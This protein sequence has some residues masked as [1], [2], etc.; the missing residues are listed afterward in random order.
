MQQILACLQQLTVCNFWCVINV[1]VS[2]MVLKRLE[3]N[4]V[5]WDLKMQV[6]QN[7][8]IQSLPGISMNLIFLVVHPVV[9]N[10]IL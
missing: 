3:A 9:A 6:F 2:T 4:R 8:L 7:V 5:L 1:F 10:D